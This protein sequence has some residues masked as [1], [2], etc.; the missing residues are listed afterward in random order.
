VGDNVRITGVRIQGPDLGV[1][2]RERTCAGIHVNSS[3]NSSVN[4]DIHN[5]ELFGWSGSAVR[6]HDDAGRINVVDNPE[7]VRIRDNY[8]HHNQHI[9]EMGYGVEVSNGAYA[10]I[11][12]NVFD[13]NRHA[14]FGDGSDGSGY[15]AYR[16]LVLEH[17][18][19]HRWI[20]FPGFWVHTHQFDMHGQKDCFPTYAF[21]CG[22]AGEYMDIQYNSFFYTEGNAFKLRGTPT[23]DANV[24]S[25]VFAHAVLFTTTFSALPNHPT[26]VIILG[27]LEQT[28]SGLD[29][30]NNL[31]GV[32]GLNE[33]RDVNGMNELT[34]VNGMKKLGVCDFDGDSINDSFLATG[35]TW[36]Y[37]SGGDR[38]WVY[39]NTS[40]KRRSQVT[41]GFF[42]GDNVCDVKVDGI[43]YPGGRTQTLPV[44]PF[45]P[46]GGVILD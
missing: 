46:G 43:I 42:N 32:N 40:L 25:N 33:R 12:R 3:I 6:I 21:N 22:K 37:S 19:L 16:N 39:L 11:E 35:Q 2:D 38:P 27:A 45:P 4:I 9:G 41:L 15:Q 20:P 7:A 24:S 14:I 28:V 31:V 23:K 8:I 29:A 13:W 36:W 44:N 17:G 18:G 10:L 30:W 26:Q 34:D 1:P 5:N